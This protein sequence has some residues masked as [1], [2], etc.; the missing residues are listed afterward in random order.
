VG[1]DLSI[2]LAQNRIAADSSY[3]V[4]EHV[5]PMRTIVV[6]GALCHGSGS[7]EGELPRSQCCYMIEMTAR[8]EGFDNVGLGLSCSVFFV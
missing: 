1:L 2:Q 6:V 5:E 7:Y 4:I 8:T 3:H